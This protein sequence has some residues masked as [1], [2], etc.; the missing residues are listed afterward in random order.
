MSQAE[1]QRLVQQFIAHQA[2]EGLA[3]AVLHRF[4]RRDVM[5]LDA[6]LAASFQHGIDELGS[7]I[8]DDHAGLAMLG[9]Q[10]DQLAN[11]TAIRG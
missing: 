3:E 8:A 7:V 11:D 4:A 1:E 5:L 2:V 9:D 10:L 6:D